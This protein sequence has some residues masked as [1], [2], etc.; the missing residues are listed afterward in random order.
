MPRRAAQ[1]APRRAVFLFVSIRACLQVPWDFLL[2]GQYWDARRERVAV[3]DGLAGSARVGLCVLDEMAGDVALGHRMSARAGVAVPA[4]DVERGEVDDR[5]DVVTGAAEGSERR[6]DQRHDAWVADAVARP[7]DRRRTGVG[8]AEDPLLQPLL[9]LAHRPT[10][11]CLDA[12]PGLGKRPEL[13]VCRAG[14]A[15]VDLVGGTAALLDLVG[16]VRNRRIAV[17]RLVLAAGDAQL[18]DR[19]ACLRLHLETAGDRDADPERRRRSGLKG[20]ASRRGDAALEDLNASQRA[21]TS[22]PGDECSLNRTERSLRLARIVVLVVAGQA[23]PGAH[24]LLP[25]P[26]QLDRMGPL[27][28]ERQS[29]AGGPGD[30]PGRAARGELVRAGAVDPRPH[31]CSHSGAGQRM[32]RAEVDLRL[33][34]AAAVL[35]REIR[36]RKAGS[37]QEPC[38]ADRRRYAGAPPSDVDDAVR[39]A[40]VVALRI[41]LPAGRVRIGPAD[42]AKPHADVPGVDRDGDAGRRHPELVVA[43]RATP[44]ELHRPEN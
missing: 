18:D 11:L 7:V 22:R 25:A 41:E 20:V 17:D 5:D 43:A 3:A 31:L 16:E 34:A 9:D 39:R 36:V 42:E 4:G 1:R 35:G 44:L 24:G 12:L 26:V 8:A 2:T 33:D 6:D 37:W 28:G 23:V 14:Q 15:G 10:R 30:E 38:V 13:V 32:R 27:A 21:R 29:A 19:I 40:Q